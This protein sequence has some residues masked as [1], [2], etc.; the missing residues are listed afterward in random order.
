M[1]SR[2]APSTQKQALVTALRWGLVQTFVLDTLDRLFRNYY[3]ATTEAFLPP[4]WVTS[5]QFAAPLGLLVGGIDGYRWVTSGRAMTSASAHRNRVIFV[6]SLLAGWALA[7][8][9]T[10]AFQW[11]L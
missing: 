3:C 1:L 8:I 11:L 2:D 9:P 5:I 10:M 7:I 6:G 4:S